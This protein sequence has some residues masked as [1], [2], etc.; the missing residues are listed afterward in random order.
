MKELSE[1]TEEALRRA[2]EKKAKRRQRTGALLAVSV[3]C[4][5]AAVLIFIMAPLYPKPKDTPEASP[6]DSHYY[7][8][9]THE[10]AL[11]TKLPDGDAEYDGVKTCL[12]VRIALPDESVFEETSGEALESIAAAL[13][14]QEDAEEDVVLTE[15]K[16]LEGASITLE[17][18]DG[19]SDSYS[20]V[21]GYVKN[22]R[23]GET[24]KLTKELASMLL[25]I[26]KKQ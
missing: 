19:S 5:L 20:V 10:A 21:N 14:W 18:A 8:L 6:E 16:E 12:L 2:D 1:Y 4:L 11:P 24:T 15:E 26:V 13:G 3:P 17:F 25:G 9:E 22:E 23:T 7:H